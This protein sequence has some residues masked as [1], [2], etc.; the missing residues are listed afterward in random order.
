MERDAEV[1]GKNPGVERGAG[2]E[3][4]LRS[5]R[6]GQRFAFGLEAAAVVQLLT[7]VAQCALIAEGPRTRATSVVALTKRYGG[8]PC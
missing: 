7:S 2:V 8:S 4:D 5:D 1:R 3:A 6:C